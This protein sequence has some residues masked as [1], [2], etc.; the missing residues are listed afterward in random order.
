MRRPTLLLSAAL[1]L[2]GLVSTVH[3][4]V[5]TGLPLDQYDAG[6]ES[7]NSTIVSNGGFE[8][9][10][11]PQPT[12]WTLN[13]SFQVGTPQG[14]NTDNSGARAAQGPL[15][16]ADP[17]DP[18]FNGYSQSISLLPGT[19]YVLSAYLWNFGQNFDLTVAEVRT[20]GGTFITN[21]ALTRSDASAQDP[22]LM[23]DG[24]RG[25]FG[26]RGFNSGA[27]GAFN[28]LVKFDTDETVAGVR[29]S[30]AGQ[31]DNVAI[32]PLSEFQA[33]RV[34]EPASALAIALAGVIAAK[35]RRH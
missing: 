26:F 3:A 4:N 8:N 15:G 34:P 29:P 35:R 17:A 33:P 30:V 31:I 6:T 23:L 5:G 18:Q 22:G 28:V 19:D 14:G 27:G 24:S 11:G 32:T 12:G 25:V 2:V 9:L 21:I 1:M 10:T 20:A 16:A 7:T 13:N